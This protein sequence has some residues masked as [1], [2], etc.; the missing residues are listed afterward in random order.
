[1]KKKAVKMAYVCPQCHETVDETHKLC[2]VCFRCECKCVTVSCCGRHVHPG[3]AMV[4]GHCME[5]CSC[6]FCKVCKKTVTLGCRRCEFCSECCR[7]NAGELSMYKDGQRMLIP[8]VTSYYLLQELKVACR[9]KDD[10]EAKVISV[11]VEEVLPGLTQELAVLLRDYAVKCCFG[12][13]RHFK[14]H[15][16][17]HI[18]EEYHDLNPQNR[19]ALYK[20]APKF[21]VEDSL[22]KLGAG[23]LLFKEKTDVGGKLWLQIACAAAMYGK[24][25]HDVFIDHVVDL[26]HNNG[27]FV[28]KPV[29]SFCDGAHGRMYYKFLLDEKTR[30]GLSK[31]GTS[32]RVLKTVMPLLNEARKAKVF[33]VKANVKVFPYVKYLPTQWGEKTLTVRKAHSI[34][35]EDYYNDMLN[36]KL[37]YYDEALNAVTREWSK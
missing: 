11:M 5:H 15:I 30:V 1:M 10:D 9:L 22:R 19:D 37:P 8:L 6:V 4:C 3:K 27:S 26:S 2:H 17:N 25:S 18:F 35:G 14:N 31:T 23:F 34:E 21:E 7:C 13:F 36:K 32:L 12:E 20:Y 16:G 24:V 28:N 33:E 29:G